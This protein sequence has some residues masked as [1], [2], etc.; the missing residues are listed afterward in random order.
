[1]PIYAL[2]MTFVSK[3][4]QIIAGNPHS[5]YSLSPE[6]PPP[7]YSPHDEGERLADNTAQSMDTENNT[8][9]AE[10][11]P[12][13][14]IVLIIYLYYL[15]PTTRYGTYVLPTRYSTVL[16]SPTTYYGTYSLLPTTYYFIPTT[17]YLPPTTLYL[18]PTYHLLP[19][20]TSSVP[21]ST[22]L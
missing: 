14:V 18:L 12:Y 21:T 11:V 9:T 22:V 20:G 15:V 5:P 2:K 17:Y 4:D 3:F 7:A 8:H 1:M 6:T 19:T 13:Q 16:P 10:P